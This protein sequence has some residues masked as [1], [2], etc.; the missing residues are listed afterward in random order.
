MPT[1]E[2]EIT[3]ELVRRLVSAQA[4]DAVPD[5]AALPLAK[6]AAGWDSE[7]WRLGASLA[8][9]LPR[10]ALAAPL[11][12][13]EQRT[14]P[15]IAPRVEAT[16]LRVPAPVFHGVPG[17]GFPWAW[18]IVPWFDGVRG[19]DVDRAARRGWAARLGVG[20][21]ALHEPAPDD[22]PVNPF[23]GVPLATR[24]AAI[25]ERLSLLE[26]AG[27]APAQE[28]ARVRE[29]WRDGVAASSWSA[30]PVWI[31]GDLHPGNLIARG[32]DL[33][34][35]IDFGDVTAGDPAY[36]LAVAWLA[37]DH[38]GRAEFRR[39]SGDGYGSATWVRAKAWAAAVS[40][41]LL[42]QSDDN[43]DYA[44][45]GREALAEVTSDPAPLS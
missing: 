25:T 35:L 29:V 44:R 18:S 42:S 6:T 45:L 5:A 33:V 39:A 14:L 2:V 7:L 19:L 26:D 37:F 23:R 12:L 3:A 41:L 21:R 38:A 4:K 13:N 17:A 24:D 1:A 40:I 15:S 31:H 27:L 22:H 9:R 11:V 28:L 8:V 10:R 43:P 16:G 32:D 36:D 20:L 30:P 34:A